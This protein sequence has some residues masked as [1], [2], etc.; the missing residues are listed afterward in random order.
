MPL[1]ITRHQM[2]P[3]VVNEHV[4]FPVYNFSPFN[5]WPACAPVNA[6]PSASRLP[7]HDS[8]SVW[9][10]TPSL[11]GFFHPCPLTVCA[12]APLKIDPLRTNLLQRKSAQEDVRRCCKW[13]R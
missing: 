1:A 2:L 7:T 4:G 5:G 3:S 13:I 12:V 6:S 9:V 11:Q 8:G 10:A